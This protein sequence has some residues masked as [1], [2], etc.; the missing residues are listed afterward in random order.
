MRVEKL[1]ISDSSEEEGTFPTQELNSREVDQQC[2]RILDLMNQKVVLNRKS[3]AKIVLK[4]KSQIL[5]R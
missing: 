5:E 2:L 1:E 3:L 4:S